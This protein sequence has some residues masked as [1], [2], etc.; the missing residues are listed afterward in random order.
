MLSEK[1]DGVP[2]KK[3]LLWDAAQQPWD[4]EYEQDTV[5]LPLRYVIE[6]N[7]DS[8]LGEHTLLPGKARIFIRTGADG[9]GVAFVGEDHVPLTPTDREL[10]LNI[11]QSRDVKVTQ[12]KV[13]DDKINLRRD[14]HNR[15]VVW[16]TDEELKIEIE[17]FKKD[18]VTLIVTEHIPGYWKMV[19]SSHEYERKDAFTIEY[20]LTLPKESKQTVTLRYNRLNVQGENEVR[21]Y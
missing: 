8:K 19:R 12:R 7:R 4:P 21:S 16:D 3:V 5:G 10:K 18:P 9:A 20:E 15:V 14:T 6:N 1:I 17:N 11:G 2:I 13:K